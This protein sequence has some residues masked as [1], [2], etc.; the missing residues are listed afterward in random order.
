MVSASGSGVAVAS[1]GEHE[2]RFGEIGTTTEG[3]RAHAIAPKTNENA[4]GQA[5]A[6]E[7]GSECASASRAGAHLVGVDVGNAG[8]DED[9]NNADSTSI[10]LVPM[11]I[12]FPIPIA[13]PIPTPS[14][15]SSPS[16]VDSPPHP[17]TARVPPFDSRA[18][19][20]GLVPVP[21]ASAS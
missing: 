20:S 11:F 13:T 8:Y 21:P 12:V 2:N 7:S 4:N 10:R 14:T 18:S 15:I 17:Y 6:R 3:A 9:A 1:I 5:V 16:K 19:E